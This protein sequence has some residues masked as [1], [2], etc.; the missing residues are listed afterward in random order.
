MQRKTTMNRIYVFFP[1]FTPMEVILA[2][3]RERTNNGL[4]TWHNFLCANPQTGISYY[5]YSL[6]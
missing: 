3:W 2:H 6:L 5:V 1:S 4:D